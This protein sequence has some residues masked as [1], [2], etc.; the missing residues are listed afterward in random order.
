MASK[1]NPEHRLHTAWSYTSTV[2]N[3]TQT[4]LSVVFLGDKSILKLSCS[5]WSLRVQNGFAYRTPSKWSTSFIPNVFERKGTVHSTVLKNNILVRQIVRMNCVTVEIDRKHYLNN[6]VDIRSPSFW[7]IF[8]HC[9]FTTNKAL[10]INLT[11]RN[12]KIIAVLP[13]A[14][15]LI[16]IETVESILILHQHTCSQ[17]DFPA[18]RHVKREKGKK[19]LQSIHLIVKKWQIT[20]NMKRQ[21][22]ICMNS[23]KHTDP[24]MH[25]HNIKDWK[26][27]RHTFQ[28]SRC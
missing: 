24:Y 4:K 18:I 14:H 23:D 13:T 6:D 27:R 11:Q 22:K 8:H 9:L 7:N 3:F 1:I 15:D 19:S 12:G 16:M 21:N 25:K 17:T 26:K 28:V 5:Y 2:R 20:G 10:H